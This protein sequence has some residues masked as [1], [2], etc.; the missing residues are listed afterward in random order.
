M[1]AG[2]GMRHPRGT[3]VVDGEVYA[4]DLRHSHGARLP[5]R[6]VVGLRAVVA[7]ADIVQR[8][9][10]AFHL[11]PRSLCYVGLPSTGVAGF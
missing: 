8:D 5:A 4:R 9:L 10:V 6:R 7:I 11:R 3:P 2:D 1:E